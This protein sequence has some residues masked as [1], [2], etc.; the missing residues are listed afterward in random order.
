MFEKK[1]PWKLP[2][3]LSLARGSFGLD[4]ILDDVRTADV[5]G[6]GFHGIGCA[7]TCLA[8]NW[9]GGGQRVILEEKKKRTGEEISAKS[10]KDLGEDTPCHQTPV[11]RARCPQQKATV[12]TILHQTGNCESM[13][14]E[15][16]RR[17]KV[18]GRLKVGEV[19]SVAAMAIG[20]VNQVPAL[21]PVMVYGKYL[22]K[23]EAGLRFEQMTS[24]GGT[25]KRM[26]VQPSQLLI[27]D[28]SENDEKALKGEKV[29]AT[30]TIV[31]PIARPGR[32]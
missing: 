12:E 19:V 10:L 18:G 5:V 8:C 31:L 23:D 6:Q 9:P 29:T 28:L 4:E 7:E 25:G 15:V 27:R 11:E 16:C 20:S 21:I 13:N 30:P 1:E 17:R 24:E 3:D 26:W 2:A 22:G 14:C 32:A